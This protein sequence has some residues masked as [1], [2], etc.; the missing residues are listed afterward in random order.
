[1]QDTFN[2]VWREMSELANAH[3]RG[4]DVEILVPK[5]APHGDVIVRALLWMVENSEEVKLPEIRR[6]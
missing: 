4:K 6:L 1:M 3:E 2:V 5:D